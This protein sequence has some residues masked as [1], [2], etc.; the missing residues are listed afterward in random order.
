MAGLAAAFGSGAMTNTIE[1]I[2]AADVIL[3]T[4]A[5]PTENHP[6]IGAAIKRAVIHRGAKLIVIDPR[7]IELADYAL[8]WLAQKPGTDVA[9][10]NGLIHVIIKEGRWDVNFVS[11]KTE[12][13]EELKASVEKYNPPY[14][15][16]ITGIPENKIIETARLY[17]GAKTASIVY[18]MGITQHVNGT[19]AVKGLANLAML[20]GNVGKPRAGVNPLRGQNNVQGACDMGGLPNV[21]PGYQPVTDKMIREKFCITWG[22]EGLPSEPGLTLVEMMKAARKK[23]V[24]GLYIL[25]ENPSLTDP[26]TN[27]VVESLQS[28][29]FLVVQD[30]FLTETARLAHVVLPGLSFA[31]KEGT[32]TNTERRVQR[33]RQAIPIP[34]GLKP[35]WEIISEISTRMGYPMSYTK[36]EEIFNEMRQLVPAYAGITY[37]RLEEIGLQWP[38]PTLDHPG[39][40][41]LHKEKFT[42]GLGKF[43]VI[44]YRDPAE[45]PDEEFPL[46]LTTGRILYQYHTRTMTGK[47]K[48]LNE[49]AP[50]CF[51]EINTQDAQECGIRNGEVVELV[52][53]RGKIQAKAV[54]TDRIISGCIFIPF[55]FAEAAANKLTHALALDPISKIPE[56]KVCAVRLKKILTQ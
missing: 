11:E 56:Y 18:A 42:R 5:N 39:T 26:D 15:A 33:V 21:F 16:R 13:F 7:K 52:S 6:V 23:E 1:D 9:W 4:G 46:I 31:E 50:E 30:I 41:Y 19:D 12:A 2:E 14:V 45:T 36:P 51:V 55:H 40:P 38:C 37:E 34:S 10:I 24:R 22:V 49:L 53:R 44:E 43:H 3:V 8:L 48:G 32:F 27:H 54:L 20:C 25:G 47:T 28:L 17:A 35:E 29:D